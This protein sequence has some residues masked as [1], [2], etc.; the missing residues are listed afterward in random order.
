MS[1]QNVELV[2]QILPPSGTELTTLMRDDSAWAALRHTIEPFFEPSCGF[3]W[4][5]WGQRLEY[6]GLDGLRAGWLNWFEPWSSYRSEVEEIIDAGDRVLVLVR[7][8][9]R[10]P[11]SDAEVELI[12]G[13]VSLVRG[14][15]LAAIDFYASRAE[16][17]EAAGVSRRDARGGTV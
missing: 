13:G 4:V 11:G 5:A 15:K 2:Q 12:G 3:A 1:R 9:A 14:G 6:T 17:G 7:D 10:R 8:H 16:A